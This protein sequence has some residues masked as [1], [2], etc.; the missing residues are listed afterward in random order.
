[1]AFHADV[2]IA[3]IQSV[4]LG[5]RHGHEERKDSEYEDNQPNNK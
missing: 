3:R 4:V 1:M 2:D 5:V